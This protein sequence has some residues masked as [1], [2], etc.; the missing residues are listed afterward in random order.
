M[1]AK[2]FQ[3]NIY[4]KKLKDYYIH[5]QFQSSFFANQFIVYFILKNFTPR[6]T[7]DP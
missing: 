4:R 5:T 3:G 7:P 1:I 6:N 2:S